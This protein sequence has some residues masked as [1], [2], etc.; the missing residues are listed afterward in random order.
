M[1]QV[2]VATFQS[3]LR[4]LALGNEKSLFSGALKKQGYPLDFHFHL[5]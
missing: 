5:L 3:L 2:L 4:L 1:L